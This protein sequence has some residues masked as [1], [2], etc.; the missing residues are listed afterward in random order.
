MKADREQLQTEL[1]ARGLE[2][3]EAAAVSHIIEAAA[4]SVWQVISQPGQLTR[5]H[6]FCQATKVITWPGV[7]AKDTVSYYETAKKCGRWVFYKRSFT[8]HC[9]NSRRN[10][11]KSVLVRFITHPRINVPKPFP[12][13]AFWHVLAHRCPRRDTHV[14]RLCTGFDTGAE[15]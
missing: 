8:T 9:Q 2:L 5:Y 3:G 11:Q 14:G 15:A 12:W 1:A 4:D 6:P 10:K 13:L 7:R